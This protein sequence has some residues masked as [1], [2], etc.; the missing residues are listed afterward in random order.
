MSLGFNLTGSLAAIDK[1]VQDMNSD[2]EDDI[3]VDRLSRSNQSSRMSSGISRISEQTLAPGSD[4]SV[5]D[6]VS[7]QPDDEGVGAVFDEES[8]VDVFL[9]R[10]AEALLSES[11]YIFNYLVLNYILDCV[12]KA[13]LLSEPAVDKESRDSIVSNLVI[14]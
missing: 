2:D 6:A 14:S 9:K 4:L 10:S 13:D 1:W 3:E 8:A 12:G 5:N 7:K 11:K